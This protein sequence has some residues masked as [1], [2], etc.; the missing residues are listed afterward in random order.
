[1]STAC[2]RVF[3]YVSYKAVNA[4]LS[5]LTL[6]IF[7]G[8]GAAL[9]RIRVIRENRF[10]D[11]LSTWVLY[12]LLF[13]MG[14]RV[15]SAAG[16]E[17]L[18]QIGRLSIVYTLSTVAGTVVFLIIFY[19]AAGFITGSPGRSVKEPVEELQRLSRFKALADPLRLLVIVAA[20][21]VCGWLIKIN[22]FTG[23]S[24]SGWLLRLLLF[25]VG[26]DLVKN[27]ISLKETLA[28]PET[29]FLPLGVVI[30]SLAGSFLPAA[31]FGIDIGKSLAVASGFGW[32]SL[33]GV[34]ITDLGDPVLGSAAFISN[35]LRET[36]ALLTIPF[37]GRSRFPHIGI[38]IA[39]AT[40]MDVTLPLIEKSCGAD[41]VPLSITSGAALSLLVPV[42]VP[43]FFRL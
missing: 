41:S 14:F 38:G 32:Y 37:I 1:M 19:S 3:Y 35:I 11:R 6:F 20:G 31:I 12:A 16:L 17:K 4:L 43:L 29:L 18:A 28:R 25:S 30:G 42:L 23:E 2:I 39:G 7:L 40:S 10:A 21:F 13:F 9:A 27:N 34:L 15:A 26:L 8:A 5:I 33:S 36:A 22:G 24:I